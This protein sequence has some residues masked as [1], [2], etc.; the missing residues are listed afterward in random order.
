MLRIV[1]TGSRRGGIDAEEIYC[2]FYGSFI[3]SDP[4]I[5]VQADDMRGEP[6]IQHPVKGVRYKWTREQTESTAAHALA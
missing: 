2:G 1:R 6:D 3:Y 4:L 5:P